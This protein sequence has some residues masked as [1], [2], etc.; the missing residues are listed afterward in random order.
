M[1][2]PASPAA[3]VAAAEPAVEAP[4]AAEAL[5]DAPAVE[6]QQAL[7]PCIRRRPGRPPG[8]TK[9]VME[10][11]RAG[12]D[13][14]KARR[15]RTAT[16]PPSRHQSASPAKSSTSSSSGNEEEKQAPT[17]KATP[18]RRA[19]AKRAFR[20]E[21]K[22]ATATSLTLTS[23]K[24]DATSIYAALQR[25]LRHSQDPRGVTEAILAAAYKQAHDLRTDPTTIKEHA[26]RSENPA[27][28]ED[29]LPLPV[30]SL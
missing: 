9:A 15:P 1:A 27:A 3:A 28:I 10:E 29:L 6:T 16:R 19:R 5:A 26:R 30:I 20:L 4:P 8:V 11:R 22:L 13:L 17:P 23:I 24:A 14:P 12:D 2:C 18:K 25:K 21:G 7:V